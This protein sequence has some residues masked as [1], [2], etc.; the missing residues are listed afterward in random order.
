LKCLQYRNLYVEEEIMGTNA[1]AWRMPLLMVLGY[2]MV[3]MVGCGDKGTLED[4]NVASRTA[5]VVLASTTC[6]PTTPPTDIFVKR[7]GI[8]VTSAAGMATG[9]ASSSDNI[10]YKDYTFVGDGRPL[11][12]MGAPFPFALPPIFLRF[13]PSKVYFSM[14]GSIGKCGLNPDE[15]VPIL[16]PQR[17]QGPF[18]MA[19]CG[20]NNSVSAYPNCILPPLLPADFN[21]CLE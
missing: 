20:P 11:C 18:L 9:S 5:A 6:P 17:P 7:V 21:H 8:M 13:A 16:S 2:V 15:P 4:D 12:F 19:L 1:P 10:P 3:G 14:E